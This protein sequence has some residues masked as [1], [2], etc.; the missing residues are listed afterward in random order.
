MIG[1]KIQQF[2]EKFYHQKNLFNYQLDARGWIIVLVLFTFVAGLFYLSQ[3]NSLATTGY[4]IKALEEKA[5]NLRQQNKKYELEITEL[6]STARINEAIKRL[7]MVEV[8][9]V[10]YLKANGSTVAVNR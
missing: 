2:K 4:K 1:A 5:A 8:A 7:E 3:V 9:R 10:E 6:R